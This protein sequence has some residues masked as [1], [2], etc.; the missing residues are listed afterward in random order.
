MSPRRP[1]AVEETHG[2]TASART[3]PTAS[4]TPAAEL[5]MSRPIMKDAAMVTGVKAACA[6]MFCRQYLGIAPLVRMVRASCAMVVLL[7]SATPAV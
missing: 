4:A 5:E 7:V 2:W 3:L 6:A 1:S